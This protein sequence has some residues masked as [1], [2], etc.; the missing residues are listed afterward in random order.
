MKDNH[1]LL[2]F[3]GDSGVRNPPDNAGDKGSIPGLGRSPG[4][5]NGNLLQYSCAWEI[6]WT[7][8][9]GG[10]QSMWSKKRVKLDLVSKQQHLSMYLPSVITYFGDVCCS[11]SHVWLFATPWG[12]A[13]QAPPSMGFSRQEYWSGLPCPPPG[14]SSR[15]RDRTWVF[16]ISCI[17]KWVLY[18]KC[19]LEKSIITYFGGGK[20]FC[21]ATIKKSIEPSDL[22]SS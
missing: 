11:F 22:L 7:E 10:L 8:E 19:Q 2:G 3:P 4:E 6:P 14:G 17:G 21:W 9:P 12:G 1:Q 20:G 16:Y 18:H 13:H 5:G 15:P